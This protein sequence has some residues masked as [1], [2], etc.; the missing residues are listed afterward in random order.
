MDRQITCWM[1]SQDVE[2]G[3]ICYCHTIRDAPCNLVCIELLDQP[4]C[5]DKT[6]KK[7]IRHFMSNRYIFRDAGTGRI[8][9]EA[10]ARLKPTDTVVRERIDGS[11]GK[12]EMQADPTVINGMEKALKDL[13]ALGKAA[14]EKMLEFKAAGV[15]NEEQVAHTD[16]LVADLRSQGIDVRQ[17][18]ASAAPE[19]QDELEQK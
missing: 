9:S 1:C 2:T 8:I 16:Q 11:K 13:Q 17:P 5:S 19:S 12:M 18:E 10:E 6:E 14:G 4:I 3:H 7:E 15:L